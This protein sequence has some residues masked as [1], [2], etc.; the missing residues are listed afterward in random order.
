MLNPNQ[1]LPIAENAQKKKEFNIDDVTCCF[2]LKA[3]AFLTA[4]ALCCLPCCCC[5]GGCCG[6]YGPCI[7][8]S[9]PDE[10]IKPGTE[11]CQAVC[12]IQTYAACLLPATLCGCLWC[13]CG[14]FTPC[15]KC[16]VGCV[17]GV[18]RRSKNTVVPTEQ[19]MAR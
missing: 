8:N 12:M 2:T 18:D 19:R 6:R 15:A 17:A 3:S 5:C 9:F 13:G 1:T 14:T 11:R 10:S 4:D 16:V 7:T